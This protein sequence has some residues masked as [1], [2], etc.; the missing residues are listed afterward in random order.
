MR[1]RR[2]PARSLPERTRTPNTNTTDA[3]RPRSAAFETDAAGRAE[4]STSSRTLHRMPCGREPMRHQHRSRDEGSPSAPDLDWGV[5]HPGGFAVH[6]VNVEHC[7]VLREL[8]VPNS[9]QGCRQQRLIRRTLHPAERGDATR[10]SRQH[11]RCVVVPSARSDDPDGHGVASMP[12]CMSMTTT[13]TFVDHLRIDDSRTASFFGVRT[14]PAEL[15][16]SP[17]CESRRRDFLV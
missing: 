2:G 12:Q 1:C 10:R 11:L 15:R 3:R 4:S 17:T 13:S 5:R 16:P 8:V 9:S 7:A 14:I 6:D